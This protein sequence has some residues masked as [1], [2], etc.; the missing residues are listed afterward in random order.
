MRTKAACFKTTGVCIISAF[1]LRFPL[2][3]QFFCFFIFFS[4]IYFP[5]FPRR[6]VM[7][8][9]IHHTPI[10]GLVSV[11]I[12]RAEDSPLVIDMECS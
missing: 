12:I 8:F 4:L 1:C 3:S 6:C 10:D 11:R 9:V 5:P 2:T 7:L